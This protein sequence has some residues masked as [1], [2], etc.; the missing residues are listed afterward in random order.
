MGGIVEVEEC[1]IVAK[2]A[3][4]SSR[5]LVSRCSYRELRGRHSVSRWRVVSVTALCEQTSDVA[6]MNPLAQKKLRREAG[7]T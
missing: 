5:A 7:G 4:V 1:L 3:G 2:S 6:R